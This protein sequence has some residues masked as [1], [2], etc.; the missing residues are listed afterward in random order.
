M[1]E[2]P[3]IFTDVVTEEEKFPVKTFKSL[4]IL[5]S[6][7]GVDNLIPFRYFGLHIPELLIIAFAG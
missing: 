4:R 3:G 2:L 5:S 6:S 1:S 7:T